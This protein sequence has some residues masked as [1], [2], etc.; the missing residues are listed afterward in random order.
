M[1]YIRGSNEAMIASQ[2]SS[3]RYFQ[4]PDNGHAHVDS[5][6]RSLTGTGG[7]FVIGKKGGRLTFDVGTSWSSPQLELND[8]GFLLQTDQ[9]KQWSWMQYRIP[10]PKGITR[11]QRYMIYQDHAWTLTDVQ[12][13]KVIGQIIWSS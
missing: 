1:S 4:R 8:V 9:I 7:K 3:E 11:S 2:Q 13:L 6:A 10:S 5:T 12:R